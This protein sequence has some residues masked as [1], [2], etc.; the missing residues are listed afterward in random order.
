M[1]TSSKFPMLTRFWA[2]AALLTLVVPA[3]GQNL[4]GSL[5]RK[6]GP[7]VEHP[8]NR[9]PHVRRA[10]AVDLVTPVDGRPVRLTM[11]EFDGGSVT[12]LL[13]RYERS[14]DGAL[15]RRYWIH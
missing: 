8:L 15:I 10:M 2:F 11:E 5:R 9:Q 4:S 13:R 7:F 3:A 1:G 12:A 6:S 14:A